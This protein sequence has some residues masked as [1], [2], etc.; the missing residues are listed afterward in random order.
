M[1][2]AEL[3]ATDSNLSVLRQLF[4]VDGP[5]GF[6]LVMFVVNASLHGLSVRMSMISEA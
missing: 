5:T 1:P 4:A 3:V 2:Q 6:E